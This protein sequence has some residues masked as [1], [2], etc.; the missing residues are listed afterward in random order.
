LAG[1]ADIH[2]WSV[3][4]GVMA[5]GDI[6]IEPSHARSAVMNQGMYRSARVMLVLGLLAGG[7]ALTTFSTL[8]APPTNAK[9]LIDALEDQG[10]DAV[11]ALVHKGA[12]I[13]A[14]S[15]GDGTV[16]MVAAKRGDLPAVER[17]LALGADV[18]VT[19]E[20]DGTALIAAAGEGH[21][22]VVERLVAAGA[23]I[24]AVTPHDE[25]ALITAARKGQLGVVQFLVGHKANVNLGVTTATG[26]WRTPLNQARTS[27]FMAYLSAPGAHDS[28]G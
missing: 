11:S 3:A 10:I 26:Q 20:S 19:A 6:A 23:N 4:E 14:P 27:L 13:N 7:I 16:L 21:L 24:D 8:A 9:V 17:L 28:R 15:R 1:G 22:P 2:R 5:A 25:T 12:D 18:N